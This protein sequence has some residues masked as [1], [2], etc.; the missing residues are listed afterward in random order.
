MDYID[1]FGLVGSVLIGISLIPQSYKTITSNKT[2]DLSLF[3]I[4]IILIASFFMIFYGIKREVIP[5]LIANGSVAIN[6]LM[7]LYVKI[8]SLTNNDDTCCH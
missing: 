8:K 7:L 4:V 3:F 6:S 2:E 1:I 5:I